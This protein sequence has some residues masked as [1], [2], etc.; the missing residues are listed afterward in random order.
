KKKLAIIL[1]EKDVRSEDLDGLLMPCK[2]IISLVRIAVK[3]ERIPHA[4]TLAEKIKERGFEVSINIMYL[5]KW[6]DGLLKN[7]KPDGKCVD[8]LYLVD[9][10][11]GSYPLEIRNWLNKFSS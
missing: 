2:H 6:D 8:F 9:S 1:N 10:Y 7:I 3:P 5:S 4:F 11:G